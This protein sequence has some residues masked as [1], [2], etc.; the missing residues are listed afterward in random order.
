MS[1]SLYFATSLAFKFPDLRKALVARA[2]FL[3][4]GHLAPFPQFLHI[5]GLHFRMFLSVHVYR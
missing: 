3:K 2:D 5:K 4:I 1:K